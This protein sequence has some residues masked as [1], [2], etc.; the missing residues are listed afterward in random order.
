MGRYLLSIKS[1]DY[2][3]S[4]V[5]SVPYLF[6]LHSK[7]NRWVLLSPSYRR[8]KH[9]LCHLPSK[10]TQPG[11]ARCPTLAVQLY[12]GVGGG[13]RGVSAGQVFCISFGRGWLET[14]SKSNLPCHPAD[15]LEHHDKDSGSSAPFHKRGWI[16]ATSAN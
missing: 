9:R 13:G 10:I 8:R 2:E 14:H 5:L 4:D 7:P 6:K 11:E 3:P 15:P 12:H 16:S 1:T